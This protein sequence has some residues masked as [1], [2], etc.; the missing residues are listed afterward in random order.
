MTCELPSIDAGLL[1]APARDSAVPDAVPNVP[2]LLQQTT[3]YVAATSTASATLLATPTSGHL[4]VM[5]GA[6]PAGSLT[7]VTGGGTWTRATGST[8]NANIEV[9]YAT[10]DG[11]SATVTIT[12]TGNTAD[13]WLAV[14]E[15]SGIATPI[16]VD[17]ASSAAGTTS[18]ASAGT[19]AT[20]GPALVLFGAS[21]LGSNTF[22]S[23]APGTWTVM[24]GIIG[25]LMQSEWYRA[26]PAAGTFAPAASETAHAWDAALVAFRYTP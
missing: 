6:T 16:V 20:T 8:I 2:A 5:I 7:S 4:L 23:P 22:G 24:T 15:W 13:M 18:P 3:N 11:S 10:A 14:S 25:G 19:I 17:D 9:W 26:T 21:N 12:R 1:D